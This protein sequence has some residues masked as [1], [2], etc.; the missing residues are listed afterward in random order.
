MPQALEALRDMLAA[1]SSEKR[2]FLSHF[3]RLICD[4]FESMSQSNKKCNPIPR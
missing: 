2:E 1:L 3:T 4:I